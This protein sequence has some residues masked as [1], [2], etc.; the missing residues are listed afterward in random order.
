MKDLLKYA[1]E[2]NMEELENYLQLPFE[3]LAKAYILT[4]QRSIKLKHHDLFEMDIVKKQRSI[5]MLNV[6]Q[7]INETLIDQG[8]KNAKCAALLYEK[9]QYRMTEDDHANLFAL[10]L[11]KVNDDS[12][13]NHIL[14]YNVFIN[15]NYKNKNGNTMLHVASKYG[16]D[17]IVKYL[18]SQNLDY[19]ATDK[20][21]ATPLHIA[22]K[23]YHFEIVKLL[24]DKINVNAKDG[25]GQSALHYVA[26]GKYGNTTLFEYLVN[27]GADIDIKY[28]GKTLLYQAVYDNHYPTVEYLLKHGANPY[29]SCKID[30]KIN[31]KLIDTVHTKHYDLCINMAINKYY[32]NLTDQVSNFRIIIL[33]SNYMKI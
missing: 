7:N 24:C 28:H 9:L 19:E 3:L 16:H 10:L 20:N 21:T 22:I 11:C 17:H 8:L 4:Y 27:H 29:I 23:N 5:A 30:N 33:L 32:L 18:L 2:G 15:Y 12:F 25:K 13:Y 14:L 1:L 26:P 6:T 31:N